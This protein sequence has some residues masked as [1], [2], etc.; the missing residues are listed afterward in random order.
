MPG[1]ALGV[2]ALRALMPVIKKRFPNLTTEEAVNFACD[3]IE[4]LEKQHE[5]PTP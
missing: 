4:A 3:L 5:N 1:T 2:K